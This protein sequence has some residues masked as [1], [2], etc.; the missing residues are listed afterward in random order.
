MTARGT[1]AQSAA[2]AV[3]VAG[4]VWGSAALWWVM[5][6]G[7][8]GEWVALAEP[9]AY[10]VGIPSGLLALLLIRVSGGGPSGLKS[11]ARWAAVVALLLPLVVT[12]LLRRR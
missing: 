9:A 4:I 11:S 12:V 2:L 6:P 7:P 8:S 10:V 1:I 3:G 5:F